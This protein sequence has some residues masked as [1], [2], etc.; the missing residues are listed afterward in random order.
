MA[1]GGTQSQ[2][3]K[4]AFKLEYLYY[5]AAV[6]LI[7]VVCVVCIR[8]FTR[9][10]RALPTLN[11]EQKRRAM[12]AAKF[13]ASSD[14]KNT[15]QRGKARTITPAIEREIQRTPTPWG[16]PNHQE[17]SATNAKDSGWTGAMHSFTDRLLRKKELMHTNSSNPRINGSLRALLE[18]RYGPVNKEIMAEFEFTP[19]KRPLLRD[20]T[21][22]PD[23]MDNFGTHKAEQLQ[24]KL[25]RVRSIK[26]EANASH[27]GK[28]SRYA[29]VR[30]IKQPWGW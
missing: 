21:E 12:P 17:F 13:A 1:R 24:T 29:E 20:P 14:R 4:W 27:S 11:A 26:G 10:S 25:D 3:G 2:A 7:G 23:Q 19:V 5:I 6:I 9:N 30:N 18:D 15:R 16:W 8:L 22:P 28:N